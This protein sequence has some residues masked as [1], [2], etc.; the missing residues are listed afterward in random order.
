MNQLTTAD[1]ASRPKLKALVDATHVLCLAGGWEKAIP[2]LQLLVKKRYQLGLTHNVLGT[3]LMHVGR[4]EEAIDHYA[5]ALAHDPTLHEARENVVF[6]ADAQPQTTHAEAQQLRADWFAHVGKPY[7]DRRV[8]SWNVRSLDPDRQL[9]VGYVTCDTRFHSAAI[10]WRAVV[11]AH[12]D[13]I[14]PILYSSLPVEM[15]DY[16][17]KQWQA[18]FGP[19]FVDVSRY[20]DATLAEILRDDQIDILV[21]LSGFTAGNRLRTFCVKPAPI[22]IT[23]WGYATGIGPMMDVLFADPVV[24]PHDQRHTIIERVVDLPSVITYEPRVDLPDANILPCA[25]GAP[26]FAVFQRAMKLNTETLAV[27]GQILDRVPEARLLFKGGDYTPKVQAWIRSEL[28]PRRAEYVDFAYST[29]QYDHMLWYQAT[30]LSLDPWPQTGGVSSL[31]SLWMGVPVV[32]LI[33]DRVIQRTTASFLT[34]L[35]LP[36]FIAQTRDDY[37]DCAVRMVTTERGVLATIRQELRA[38]LH[39]S[40][41]MTGYVSAVETAYRNLWREFCA[42]QPKEVHG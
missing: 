35:G 38:R 27:W 15:Y 18:R 5:L 30:D 25:E 42:T 1:L 34:T 3:A 28:G 26:V 32:T 2:K 16:V 13:A 4:K 9:R 7:Y 20:D 29:N 39:A 12:S 11:D 6:F 10:A 33:G 8:P 21:D 19:A 17:T 22:Q 23:A 14:Q 36:E 24:L 41:I 40:P 31:E 37:I